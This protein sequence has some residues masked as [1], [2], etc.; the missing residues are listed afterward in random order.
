MLPPTWQHLPLP[1]YWSLSIESYLRFY[2]FNLKQTDVIL[3]FYC[4]DLLLR[5]LCLECEL[6]FLTC[7]LKSNFHVWCNL[8]AVGLEDV[9][10]HAISHKALSNNAICWCI[11]GDDSLID[12]KPPF[13]WCL[14]MAQS[15]NQLNGRCKIRVLYYFYVCEVKIIQAFI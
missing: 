5:P 11:V 1:H 10:E 13:N 3:I 15:Q 9:D 6:V 4:L 2:I 8:D 7:R 14:S 12:T